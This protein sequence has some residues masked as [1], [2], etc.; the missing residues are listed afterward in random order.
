MTVERGNMEKYRIAVINFGSTST[1]V[2]YYEDD[3]RIYVENLAHSAEELSQFS[4]IFDQ[5]DYRY[6]KI[7]DCFKERGI[8]LEEMDCIASRCGNIAPRPGGV[9]KINEKMAKEAESGKYGVHPANLGPL[10]ALKIAALG[11]MIPITADPPTTDEFNPLARYSGLPEIVR[12]SSFQ[13]L[14]QRAVGRKYAEQ[15][16]KKYEDLR[17]II[18]HM[19]GGISVVAHQ[20]G[21]MTDAN[22]ALDGDGPFST[23]RAGALPTGSL[24]DMCFS[25]EFTH[26]EMRR[27]ING[28]GGLIAY[29]G[30]NDVK[31]LTERAERDDQCAETLE[32][33]CYQ[34]TK[35]IGSAAAVLK[36][37]VDAILISGGMANSEMLMKWIEERISF[38]APV[39]LYPGEFEMETLAANGLRVLR[40]EIEPKE[41]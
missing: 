12:M 35:E 19:G 27:K 34:V 6:E 2:A 16:G 39:K 11:N 30:E 13:A 25:G 31:E 28:K 32:A 41:I 33:M 7:T 3:T 37:D 40:G 18:C 17:L 24:I 20:N 8:A 5:L 9:Y 14:N 26:E 23:N 4:K 1:K 36:G 22:N 15:T 38:I 21:K 29:T 10:I